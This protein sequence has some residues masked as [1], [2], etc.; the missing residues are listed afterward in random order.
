MAGR[1]MDPTRAVGS[2]LS[3]HQTYQALDGIAGHGLSAWYSTPRSCLI[4]NDVKFNLPPVGGATTHYPSARAAV[5]VAQAS[6][7]R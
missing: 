3:A 1:W 6:E 7:A 5:E 2:E 4:D